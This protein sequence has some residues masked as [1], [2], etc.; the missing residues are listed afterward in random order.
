[1]EEDGAAMYTAIAEEASSA[2]YRC[3]PPASLLSSP[4]K[5]PTIPAHA[6][7]PFLLSYCSNHTSL[8]ISPSV[9]S[10]SADHLYSS[11]PCHR[12]RPSLP[13]PFLLS[14]P[15]PSRAHRSLSIGRRLPLFPAA[16]TSST[17]SEI[18][19]RS[20]L[21]HSSVNTYSAINRP[22]A[23]ALSYTYS[24]INPH[25]CRLVAAATR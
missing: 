19:D 20:P 9:A 11:P 18:H 15:A 21:V 25:G 17:P 5:P 1:M 12:R 23:V 22:T 13:S 10:S 3:Q 4:P 24:A 16:A 8:L 2:F 6:A 7:L 14:L